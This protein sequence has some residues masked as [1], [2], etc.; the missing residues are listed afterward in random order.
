[1]QEKTSNLVI[2]FTGKETKD[3]GL[4][5]KLSIESSYSDEKVSIKIYHLNPILFRR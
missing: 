4:S 2:E 1:L 3:Y 5:G